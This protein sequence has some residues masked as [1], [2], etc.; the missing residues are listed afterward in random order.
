VSVDWENKIKIKSM[1][2]EERNH[3]FNFSKGG[4]IEMGM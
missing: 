1:K 3:R 2:H 4:K